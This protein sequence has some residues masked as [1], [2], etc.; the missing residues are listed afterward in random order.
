MKIQ[1]LT[2]SHT[3]L[4]TTVISACLL[5]LNACM[6]N[7]FH[8]GLYQDRFYPVHNGGMN[9][10]YYTDAE[11]SSGMAPARRNNYVSWNHSI[12]L[13]LDQQV[14]TL[15]QAR[16]LLVNMSLTN[17]AKVTTIAPSI[18]AILDVV[19]QCGT[20]CNAIQQTFE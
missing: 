1:R 7:T 2:R 5:I 14:T 11:W 13:I 4:K 9:A 18:D 19:A 17:G 8:D 16:S 3:A 12:D 10:H 20:T 6:S 15:H